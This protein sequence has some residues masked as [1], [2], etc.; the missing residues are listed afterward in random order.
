MIWSVP[1]RTR[2][3]HEQLETRQQEELQKLETALSRV[4]R[5]LQEKEMEV[6][7]W[8]DAAC[9]LAQRVPESSRAGLEWVQPGI[10]EDSG[11]SF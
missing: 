2:K 8:K 6:S 7:R 11:S 10:L 5:R 3:L 4:E 9:L 1:V